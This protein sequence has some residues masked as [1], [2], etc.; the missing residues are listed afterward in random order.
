MFE[1]ATTTSY[2]LTT[3]QFLIRTSPN[4]HLPLR[5]NQSAPAAMDNLP[6]HATIVQPLRGYRS[7]AVDTSLFAE[8]I[9]QVVRRH[10]T[11]DLDDP[12][13]GQDPTYLIRQVAGVS[14]TIAAQVQRILHDD[15]PPDGPTFY[16]VAPLRFT[17]R[18]IG[19]HVRRWWALKTTLA[20]AARFLS[21]D[22]RPTLDVLFADIAEFCGGAAIRS[23]APGTHIFRARQTHS[24]DTALRWF[25]A[26]DDSE[27]RAPDR[28]R[29]NRMNAAGIRA[30]YGALQDSIAVAEVQ[31][32][33]GAHVVL[34]A[35]TPIRPLKVLD[36]GALGD[37]FEY[38]DIFDP[39][40]ATASERLTF[41]RMLEQEISLPIHFTDEPLAY[42]PTQVIAEYV[43]NVLRLDGLA[44]RSSQTGDAPSWG[45][46]Y[47]A[48]LDPIERNVVL[49][50]SAALTTSEQLANGPKPGLEF[51]PDLKQIVDI[52][53]IKIHHRPHPNVPYQSLPSQK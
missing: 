8:H 22:A 21:T 6:R 20:S 19:P 15:E 46:L 30:F 50:G 5:N 16:N 37:V 52:T 43:H 10:Y 7:A 13:H 12:E 34:G 33:I 45:Q 44:Y 26:S 41:F 28:P 39:Q 18:V 24:L 14:S 47:G 25:R 38:S 32:P 1:H 17:T 40:F 51:L 4:G 2:L 23:L 48:R 27:L 36:L 9:D 11:P 42:I 31:P 35:F 49:L 53:Q 3:P 29:A